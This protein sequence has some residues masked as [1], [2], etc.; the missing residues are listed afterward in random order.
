MRA[1]PAISADL[2]LERTRE[3]LAAPERRSHITWVWGGTY[4]DSIVVVY[5]WLLEAGLCAYSRDMAEYAQLFDPVDET[6]LAEIASLEI[7]EPGKR[8]VHVDDAVRAIV[9][10]HLQPGLSWDI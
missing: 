6:L 2:V 7:E 9:P 8:P 3:L 1:M 10:L 4:R 5:R